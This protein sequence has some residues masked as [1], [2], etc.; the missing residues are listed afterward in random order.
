LVAEFVDCKVELAYWTL[1]LSQ[2][3]DTFF[4]QFM[5]ILANSFDNL[6]L[7]IANRTLFGFV[8]RLIHYSLQ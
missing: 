2:T 3:K 6:M 1:A 8:A 5:P 7:L 4:T